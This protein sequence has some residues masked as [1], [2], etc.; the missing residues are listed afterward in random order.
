MKCPNCGTENDEDAVFCKK[1]GTKIE[2]QS[3]S[4]DISWVDKVDFTKGID[5]DEKDEQPEQ[6]KEEAV[7]EVD[8]SQ[9]QRAQIWE[10]LQKKESRGKAAKG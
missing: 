3:D 5:W 8:L 4:E 6:R 9:K 1:C 10:N 2:V 7:V